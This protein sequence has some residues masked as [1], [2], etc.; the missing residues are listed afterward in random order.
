MHG[1]KSICTG[2]KEAGNREACQHTGKMGKATFK[3]KYVYVREKMEASGKMFVGKFFF[4]KAV[5]IFISS[6]LKPVLK[7]QGMSSSLNMLTY[8][9]ALE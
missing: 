1:A 4:F 5:L 2:Q 9:K 6:H 8:I 3:M 7:I